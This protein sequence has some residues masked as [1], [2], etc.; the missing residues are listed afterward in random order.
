MGPSASV[1]L[2]QNPPGRSAPLPPAFV[3]RCHVLPARWLPIDWQKRTAG[4]SWSH[5]ATGGRFDEGRQTGMTTGGV[6][7]MLPRQRQTLR[8]AGHGRQSAIGNA[9][10]PQAGT[11]RQLGVLPDAA[12]LRSHAVLRDRWHGAPIASVGSQTILTRSPLPMEAAAR[13]GCGLNMWP[14][15][16]PRPARASTRPA[17]SRVRDRP[18]PTI[19]F[20][21]GSQR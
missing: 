3:T 4:T 6:R 11:A 1:T 13:T 16:Q 2:C 10:S 12:W 20:A 8:A 17:L 19:R 18:G 9:R 5:Q 15:F 21:A 7:H 14:D